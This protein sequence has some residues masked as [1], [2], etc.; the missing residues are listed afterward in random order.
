M[1]DF[2]LHGGR[3]VH[4]VKLKLGGKINRRSLEN[5]L[6]LLKIKGSNDLTFNS[7]SIAVTWS[8]CEANAKS[9]IDQISKLLRRLEHNIVGLVNQH[10]RAFFWDEVTSQ[11]IFDI[12][13]K[14][15]QGPKQ[16]KVSS[17]SVH[18]MFVV[19]NHANPWKHS[20]LQGNK[21]SKSHNP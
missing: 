2:L 21:G 3:L 19:E 11:T 9:A 4:F 18:Q 15:S 7:F 16:L 8:G 6:T 1:F 20:S 5:V 13:F 14:F 12:L 17:I 10:Q